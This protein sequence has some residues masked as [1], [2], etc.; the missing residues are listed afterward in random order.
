MGF[1]FQIL[2]ICLYVYFIYNIGDIEKGR[3]KAAVLYVISVLTAVPGFIFH[4]EWVSW[5]VIT[6]VFLLYS[7]FYDNE[8]FKHQWKAIITYGLCIVLMELGERYI[9]YPNGYMISTA[10]CFLSFL[11]LSRER[12]YLNRY[13]GIIS[14]VIYILLLALEFVF[15]YQGESI[16]KV[17]NAADISQIVCFTTA[18]MLFLLLEGALKS[19][20]AGYEIS[21]REFQQRVLAHQYEEIKNIYMDMRGWRHDYH[22]HIQVLKAQMALEKYDEVNDYLDELEQDLDRV[23]TYVK[24]GNLMADAILNSKLSMA[25]ARN[26][27]ISCKAEL[28]AELAVSDIDL[29]V[30]LGNLLDNA[31]EACEKIEEGKRFI[32]IYIVV[33]KKQLYISIQNS[34]KEELDF[35]E[36]HYISTK[37]GNHGLGMKRV[38]LAVDKY[39]GFLNL[40]NEPGIFAA[41]VSIPLVR[42]V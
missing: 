30:I 31:L 29:C 24:S 28:P 7:L 33:N 40:Q 8:P 2:W 3:V 21:T 27:N 22:N 9:N 17:Q 42:S 15:D 18:L 37:R 19:Y 38:K 41:E 14:G 6:L 16:F 13:N 36:R 26:I 34:A 35:N 11:W 25:Q 32:R 20:Q 10:I 4:I 23:D 39:E 12:G 5:L 1:L